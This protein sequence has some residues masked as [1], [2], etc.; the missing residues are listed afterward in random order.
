MPGRKATFA[1]CSSAWSWPMTSSI[2]SDEKTRPGTRI[3]AL[4]S[5]GR[6]QRQSS[7]LWRMSFQ[8]AIA[9]TAMPGRPS[10]LRAHGRLKPSATTL[11]ATTSDVEQD[12]G[13]VAAVLRRHLQHVARHR[14]HAKVEPV[15]L[16]V[17]SL[18]EGAGPQPRLRRLVHLEAGEQHLLRVQV[19]QQLRQPPH[20]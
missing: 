8:L 5:F 13:A 20:E 11:Y 6:S 14:L 12:S 19:I 3:P 10:G 18:A 4:Y 1:T 16:R 2:S 7:T 9:V 17:Y 15:A